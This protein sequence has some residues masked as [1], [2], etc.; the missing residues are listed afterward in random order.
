M[1]Y[2]AGDKILID[3]YNTFLNGT[4]AGNYGINHI[5][6]TGTGNLG[7]GQTALSLNVN[8]GEIITA[9]QWNSLFSAME[10]VAN[11]ANETLAVSTRQRTA[12]EIIAVVASLNSDIQLLAAAVQ[13]GCVNTTALTTGSP[14]TS[15]TTGVWDTSHIAEYTYTFTGGDQARW[16]F[17]AGG[18]LRIS[19]ANTQQNSTGLDTVVTGLMINIGNFDIGATVSTCSGNMNDD[20]SNGDSNQAG[21]AAGPNPNVDGRTLGYYDLTTEYSTLLDYYE[22]SGTYDYSYDG[23]VSIRVEAKT[24]AAHGDGRGNNGNVITV[25]VSIVNTDVGYTKGGNYPSI[26]GTKDY[27]GKTSKIKENSCGP[28]TISFNSRYPDNSEGLATNLGSISPTVAKVAASYTE[29]TSTSATPN[30]ITTSI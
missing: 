15:L 13:G 6:G 12:G 10:N 21:S 11:H 19:F 28:T 20:S 3:Q 27:D 26:A 25:R 2:S 14:T 23:L 29:D 18:K 4:T 17:N 24:N 1:A 7:M 16:F 22:S 30:R 8:T 9:A 5:I